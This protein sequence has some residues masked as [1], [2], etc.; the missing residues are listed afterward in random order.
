MNQHQA[1]LLQF[2]GYL[3]EL[4]SGQSR[5]RMS[6]FPC[7]QNL[8][9]MSLALRIFQMIL[10]DVSQG[11]LEYPAAIGTFVMCLP[12]FSFCP[13]IMSQLKPDHF[14]TSLL[15]LFFM[16]QHQAML[17]QFFGYLHELLSGQSRLRMSLFPCGQNLLDMGLALR[18]FQMIL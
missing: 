12:L 5:L 11:E 1:M 18:I 3:H 6:L 17:L 10:L 2:F 13:S 7:S 4:L 15:T 8:L 16:N 14:F 9:D